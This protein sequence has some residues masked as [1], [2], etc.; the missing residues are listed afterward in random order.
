MTFLEAVN[1]ILIT[2]GIIAGDDDEI[3]TFDDIQHKANINLSKIAIDMTLSWVVS[4]QLIPTEYADGTITYVQSQRLYDLPSNFV[5]FAYQ[6]PFLLELDENGESANQVVIR[7][8][9]DWIRRTYLDYKDKEGNP[10]YFYESFGDTKQI[11]LLDIPDEEHAGTIVSFPYEKDVSVVNSTDTLP[12][13][14]TAESNAF[15]DMAARRFL[16]MFTKQPQQ[17]LETDDIYK[18]SKA[19]LQNLM[20]T[21]TSTHAY[22]WRYL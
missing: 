12:F 10:I 5:R 3:G 13:R 1:R 22:G 4:E 14:T 21:Y 9:E 11:G 19:T 18:S 16:F 15:V 17:G 20:R 2:T 7:K 8:D 6:N